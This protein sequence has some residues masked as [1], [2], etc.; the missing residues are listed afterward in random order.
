VAGRK[1]M[2]V[3]TASPRPLTVSL[4]QMAYYPVKSP[5]FL[6][7]WYGEAIW[8]M[9]GEGKNVY[10]S[11]DDGPHPEITPWVL[12]QLSRYQ[13]KAVFFCIGNNVERYPQHFQEI[14]QQGHA[15]GNHTFSH[16]NGWKTSTEEYIDQIAKAAALIPSQLFRP[17]YGR[18][19]RKQLKAIKT[20]FPPMK[21]IMWDV[22]SGDF[23]TNIDANQCITN[24][25]DNVTNG[26]VIVFHDSEKAFPRLEKTLPV[27][28]E[29]LNKKNFSFPLLT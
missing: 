14:I 15:V 8:K 16:V 13:A 22:L 18:I 3:K 23:D 21:T 26:S 20:A 17:P 1:V 4:R 6:R 12:E 9:P 10:L 7:Y 25:L 27:V 2:K 28:L 11:F 24:V 29:E 5:W 19:T